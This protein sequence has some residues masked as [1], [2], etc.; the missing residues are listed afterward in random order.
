MVSLVGVR[1]CADELLQVNVPTMAGLPLPILVFAYFDG[2][3]LSA[4][5]RDAAYA[6]GFHLDEFY[7]L[8]IALCSTVAGI[9]AQQFIHR[10][11]TSSNILYAGG[12]GSAQV[13][14]RIID[15]GISTPFPTQYTGAQ[16][17]S[18]S[19]QGTLQFLSPEQTGRMG[20]IVD[21]R[22]DI[23]SLGQTNNSNIDHAHT[24]AC[25]PAEVPTQGLA[26]GT[27]GKWW[28]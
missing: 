1:V 10:D 15:F 8:A 3:P 20:R 4:R 24:S 7:P 17:V 28:L 25:C 12:G 21:Y 6:D 18:K 26:R 13:N 16:N 11:L 5:Y 19:L 9:H 14:V 23:Y 22:T 27:S 2:A